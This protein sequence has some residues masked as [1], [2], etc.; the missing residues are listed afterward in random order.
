MA[1]SKTVYL[2][3][4]KKQSDKWIKATLKAEVL[5]PEH[6]QEYEGKKFIKLNININPEP[7]KYGKDVSISLDT[8]KPDNKGDAHEEPAQSAPVQTKKQE[9]YGTKNTTKHPFD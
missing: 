6:W 9:D 1:E 7:D 8:W 3:S 2:G 5:N 4:G